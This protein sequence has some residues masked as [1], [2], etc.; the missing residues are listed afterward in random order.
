MQNSRI[1]PVI[2]TPD[3]RFREEESLFSFSEN[4]P[5]LSPKKFRG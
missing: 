4:V 1:F 3:L 2:N 5:K